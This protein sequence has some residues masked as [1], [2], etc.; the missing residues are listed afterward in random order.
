MIYGHMIV[1]NGMPDI[2]R[3]LESINWIADKTYVVDCFSTDGTYEFLK[4]RE[5]IYNLEIYQQ[6]YTCLRDLR[7]WLMKKIPKDSWVIVIDADEQLTQ[8]AKYGLKTLFD[9]VPQEKLLDPGRKVPYVI[10]MNHFNLINDMYHYGG[11]PIAHF[12]KT[13]YYDRD[14][15]W[16]GHPF[17]AHITYKSHMDNKDVGIIMHPELI[18]GMGFLHYA[19]LNPKRLEWRKKVAGKDEYGGYKKDGW[20]DETKI[21]ELPPIWYG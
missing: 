10:A 5:K 9:K 7:N 15:I 21:Y 2:L 3:A 1:Q 17:H 20:T 14:L 19:R 13:F 11:D 4:E 8:I 18:E 12:Q 6:K 16:Y